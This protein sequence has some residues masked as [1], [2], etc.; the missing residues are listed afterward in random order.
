MLNIAVI[1]LGAA[2]GANARYGLSLWAAER[3]GTA[4]PYGT[5]II[6]VVGSFLIGLVMAWSL[7]RAPLSEPLRLLVVTGIL[8]GFTTFS[9]F[10]YEAYALIVNGNWPL[11]LLYWLGSVGLGFL[12]VVLGFALV[13]AF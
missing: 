1:A 6:N 5:F 10:S 8:G 11:A 7:T 9:S 3:F 2:L 13:R 4:F 12:G